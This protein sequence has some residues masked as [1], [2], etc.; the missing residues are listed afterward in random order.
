[1]RWPVSSSTRRSF[2]RGALTSTGPAAVTTVRGRW[3]P[4]RTTGRCPL[5]SVS[6]V[7]SATYWLTSASSAAASIRRA[8]SRTISS[9]KEPD[10]VEPS[11]A[12]TLS[13]SMPSRPAL[14]RGPTRR[15]SNDHREGTP[16]ASLPGLI[17][18]FRALLGGHRLPAR[19]RSHG[20]GAGRGSSGTAA[21]YEAERSRR[22]RGAYSS[23]AEALPCPWNPP[24][25][26]TSWTAPVPNA[27]P[28]S[29]SARWPAAANTA[30]T[31]AAGKTARTCPSSGSA[32]SATGSSPPT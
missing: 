9:I 22:H 3:W 7:N 2:T 28:D 6:A 11:S 32:R 18:R 5:A 31:S 17:H 21:R 27:A 15:P 25:P 8:P 19:R 23:F 26:Q 24:T 1:M 16:S 20:L 30:R 14:Q 10:W 13:T 12:T 4:L 29:R